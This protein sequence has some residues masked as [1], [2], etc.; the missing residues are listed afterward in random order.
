METP[1]RFSIAAGK[2]S[3]SGG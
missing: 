2:T 3:F 1:S